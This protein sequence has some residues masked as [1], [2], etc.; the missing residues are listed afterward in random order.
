[1]TDRPLWCCWPVRRVLCGGSLSFLLCDVL[2]LRPTHSIEPFVGRL[3]TGAGP[4]EPQ[5]DSC[6]N[7][8][9]RLAARK[10]SSA[11]SW[12]LGITG[13]PPDLAAQ[14]GAACCGVCV[15]STASGQRVAA[16]S[17]ELTHR[18]CLSASIQTRCGLG[19]IVWPV[20][21]TL[22]CSSSGLLFL[23]QVD[24]AWLYF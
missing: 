3:E 14:N 10:G 4:T 13:P 2:N 15:S 6:T 17:W 1:M 21:L 16:P 24:L 20:C 19:R 11:G 18:A 5:I 7:P 12:G 9:L 8:L 22:L 23:L